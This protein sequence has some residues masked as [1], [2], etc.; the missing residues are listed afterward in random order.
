[1]PR[2]PA[3]HPDNNHHPPPQMPNRNDTHLSIIEAVIL[4]V[5]GQACEDLFCIGEV[6]AALF[7]LAACF[8]GSKVIFMALCNYNNPISQ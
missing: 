5:E 6:K 8:A 1:M 3:R 2:I 7:K 4:M